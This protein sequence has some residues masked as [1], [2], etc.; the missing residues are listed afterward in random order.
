MVGIADDVAAH[1]AAHVAD[2]DESNLHVERSPI[3]R[4]AGMIS[5]ARW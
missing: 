4:E 1:R 2:A 5:S 3:P